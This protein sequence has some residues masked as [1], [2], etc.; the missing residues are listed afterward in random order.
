MEVRLTVED[1]ADYSTEELHRES[2]AGSELDV[3]TKLQVLKKGDTLDHRV[4]AVERTV[5]VGDGAAGEDVCGNHLEESLTRG[6][7]FVETDRG[8]EGSIKSAE[9]ERDDGEDGESPPWEVGVTGVVRYGDE[10]ERCI[11]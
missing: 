5:H 7:E 9:D 1:G 2:D 11:L 8:S 4:L 10:Y 6:V 3:L